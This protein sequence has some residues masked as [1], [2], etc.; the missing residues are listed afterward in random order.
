M[1]SNVLVLHCEY[2]HLCTLQTFA[3]SILILTTGLNIQ[4]CDNLAWFQILV[5][6]FECMNMKIYFFINLIVAAHYKIT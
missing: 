2:L 5:L 4:I 1:D 3:P 6:I